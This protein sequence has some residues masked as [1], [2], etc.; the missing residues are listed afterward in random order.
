[1]TDSIPSKKDF[2]DLINQVIGENVMNE[3]KMDQLLQ[4][5]KEN[6]RSHGVE[7]L[8]DYMRKVTGAPLSSDQMKQLMDSMI[9]SRGPEEALDR[10]VNQQWLNEQQS[11]LLK[12]GILPKNR[13]ARR[14]KKMS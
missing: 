6:Y 5:A 10:L 7:G 4:Q 2:A 8:F 9:S 13:Q 12:Q 1:M 14:G 11:K 3:R